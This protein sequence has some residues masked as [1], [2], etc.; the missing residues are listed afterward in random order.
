M[1][2]KLKNNI[3]LEEFIKISFGTKGIDTLPYFGYF[4]TEN[5]KRPFNAE[6]LGLILNV[7]V[8]DCN[9]EIIKLGYETIDDKAIW[10]I[11]ELK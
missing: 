8:I 7:D 10:D 3:D 5:L 4:S 9:G 6:F 1:I 2:V 11:Y